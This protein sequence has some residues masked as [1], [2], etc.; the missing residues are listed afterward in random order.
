MSKPQTDLKSFIDGVKQP[1]E[2]L[3]DACHEAFEMGFG[4]SLLQAADA[5]RALE[6]VDLRGCEKEHPLPWQ[7][8][9]RERANGNCADRPILDANGSEVVV[10]DCG[11]YPPELKTCEAMV[12]CMNTVYAL[13][14]KKINQND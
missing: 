8:D 3:A 13:Q 12:A 10:T 7:I 4:D 1:L 14:N 11:I 5:L 6:S 9:E 2:R